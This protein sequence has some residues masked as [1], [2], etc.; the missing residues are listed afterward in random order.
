MLNKKISNTL[1]T[2]GVILVLSGCI[3]KPG[4]E[5]ETEQ[6]IVEETKEI[7][8][9]PA[10]SVPTSTAAPSSTPTP[11]EIPP[12]ATPIVVLPPEPI[13]VQFESSDGQE[14]SGLYY[15]ADENPAPILVLM[16][17]SRGNQ[18]EWEEIAYW[19]QG[20]GLLVR[21]INTRE[22]WKNSRWYPERTL[23][24]P[25]GVFTFNF[26]ACEGDDGC[27]AYLPAEW[28]LDAQA[29]LETAAKLEGADPEKLIA[30]GASI[31]ADGAVDSCA[32][33]NTTDQGKC[34]GAFALSPA[35]F[36]TIDFRTATDALL[37]QENPAVVYCLY[38]LRDAAPRDTC[39]NY[40]DIPT[41]NYGHIFDHGL[42]L[43]LV[44]RKPDPLNLLQEFI[45]EALGGAQ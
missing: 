20:R 5:V 29:A 37:A 16:S 26:R 23:E 34:L 15:P 21:E 44:D 25:L 45:L 22:A 31:G 1:I 3:S 39:E 33:L 24:M 38:G 17:W 19:L 32:W 28:L 27:Q 10:T 12:T 8:A 7:T 4:A 42:E 2:V 43:I 6:I 13:K 18:S 36:L 35:S 14:L 9:L 40:P 11:T 41:V 30:A